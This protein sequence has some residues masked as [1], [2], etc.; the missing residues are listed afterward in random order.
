MMS[1]QLHWVV[2]THK[3]WSKVYDVMVTP[4][5]CGHSQEV[6]QYLKDTLIHAWGTLFTPIQIIPM[7]MILVG[8]MGSCY[9]R[10]KLH[11]FFFWYS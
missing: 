3:K 11:H 9:K 7:I 6:E 1:W 8:N 2:D 4:L 5:G 10:N